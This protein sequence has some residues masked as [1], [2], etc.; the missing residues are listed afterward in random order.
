V[1]NIPPA[2]PALQLGWYTIRTPLRPF[3]SLTDRPGYLSIRGSAYPIDYQES[4]SALLR[5]QPDFEGEWSTGMD[6]QPNVEG[7]AAGLVVWLDKDAH[8]TL[9]VRGTCKASGGKGGSGRELVFKAPCAD[10]S[11]QVS[12]G[13]SPQFF[14]A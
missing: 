12:P 6:F 4:P 1:L 7:T 14:R 2:L 9:S 5:K 10:R 8:I 3:H 13:W 11:F